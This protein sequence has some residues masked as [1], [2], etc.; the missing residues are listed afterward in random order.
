MKLYD[1]QV[2]YAAGGA[3]SPQQQHQTS[4][5]AADLLPNLAMEVKSS[6]FGGD[7]DS[8]VEHDPV[9][10]VH[11]NLLTEVDQVFPFSN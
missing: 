11:T 5:A 1:L 7:R 2:G 4:T 9:S 10:G 6:I 3:T 8:A